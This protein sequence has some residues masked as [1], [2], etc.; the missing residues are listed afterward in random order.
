MKRRAED[1]EAFL[2]KRANE[3][4]RRPTPAEKI[5]RDLLEPLGFRF[6]VPIIGHTKN[7]GE[8]P[9]ILD[10]YYEEARLAV[11]VDGSAHRSLKGRD[12]RRDTR[13]ALDG[14]RTLRFTNGRV[15]KE[16]GA[17]LAEIEKALA[18]MSTEGENPDDHVDDGPG[19]P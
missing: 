12:R 17:V 1:L 3:M 15:L 16:S 4:R 5:L 19:E 14:I 7:G 2:A 9:Y 8:H 10:A 11:E 18:D 6:Q 13:L